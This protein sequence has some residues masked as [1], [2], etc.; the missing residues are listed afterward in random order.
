MMSGIG[1]ALLETR[2]LH[3]NP[4][5]PLAT[6]DRVRQRWRHGLVVL[7]IA[8]T[9]ALLVV[10]GGML[11][12]YQKQLSRDIG[13][14]THPLVALRVENSGG[15]SASRV[16]DAVGQVPGVAAVSAASSVPYMGA[17]PLDRV[18]IDAAGTLTVRAERVSIG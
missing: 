18:S 13:F 5:R 3:G 11:N 2:R 12:T 16:V 17:G 1:P 8:V 10:T 4:M 9:V 6:S 14:N 15:V 7:E